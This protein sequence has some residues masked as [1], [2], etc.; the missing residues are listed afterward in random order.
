L[1]SVLAG[2]FA[3]LAGLPVLGTVFGLLLVV[4]GLFTLTCAILLKREQPR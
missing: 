1:F 2:I 3:M 4:S